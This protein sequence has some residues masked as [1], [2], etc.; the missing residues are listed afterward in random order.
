MAIQNGTEIATGSHEITKYEI[1]QADA[2]G[3][4]YTTYT[5]IGTKNSELG[6]IQVL[7]SSGTDAFTYVQAATPSQGYFAYDATTK[8]ITFAEG[9]EPLPTDRLAV[10]YTWRTASNAEKITLRTDAIP[11]VVLVSAY[12]LARDNCSGELFP[13][14]LEGQAQ[15]DGNW[16]FEMVADGDPI[17]QSLN[18][19]FVK[20][21]LEEKLYD[22]VVYTEDEDLPIPQTIDLSV[23]EGDLLGMNSKQLA[24]GLNI[25]EAG[26]V[27]GTLNWVENYTGFSSDPTEQNGWYFP[28]KVAIPDGLTADVTATMQV[29]KKPP[30]DLDLSDGIGIVFMGNSEAVARSKTIT[31]NI[32][33]DAEGVKYPTETLTFDMRKVV[34]APKA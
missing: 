9:D 2:A 24:T 19:E 10:A 16:S 31:L 11:A 26:L 8:Q 1:I 28:F 5:A 15:V 32:D 34:Y 6:F 12:G 14:I 21:C 20:G 22:F 7:N 23:P 17:V 3:N 27:T 33:W 25:T 30:K 29:G 13:C 4:F 18:M